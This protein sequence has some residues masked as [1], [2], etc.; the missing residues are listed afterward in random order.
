[1]DVVTGVDALL[2]FVWGHETGSAFEEYSD[3]IGIDGLRQEN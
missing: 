1:M 3:A 2:V